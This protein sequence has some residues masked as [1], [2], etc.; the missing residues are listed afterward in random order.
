[1]APILPSALSVLAL[2]VA[3]TPFAQPSGTRRRQDGRQHAQYRP[4]RHRR[5]VGRQ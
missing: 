2:L 4:Y 1:M 5:P 3:S